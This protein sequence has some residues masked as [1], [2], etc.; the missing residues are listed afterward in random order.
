MNLVKSKLRNR[1]NIA[2]V[3]AVLAIR[4]GMKRVGKSCDTFELPKEVVSQIGTMQ[5]YRSEEESE[6]EL[7]TGNCISTL[8]E[9]D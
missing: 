8:F 3:N 5:V 2:S 9:E 4:C 6:L 7:S 1:I